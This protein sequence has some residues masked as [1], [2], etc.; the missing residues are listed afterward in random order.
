MKS[1]T[2]LL[3]LEEPHDLNK[4]GNFLRDQGYETLMCASPG[5]GIN[6]LETDTVS[7]VIVG[8]ETPAFQGREVL[9]YSLRCH[10]EIPVLVVARVLDIHCYLEA[11][12]LG[13]R[14]YL[15]RPDPQDLAWVVYTQMHRVGTA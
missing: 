1:R 4:Y 6:S 7:L 9:E 3:I 15:E 10:P 14:D 12:E 5:E 11:M 2:V 13:A 8:Q